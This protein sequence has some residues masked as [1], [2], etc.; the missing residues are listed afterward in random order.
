MP[1]HIR[2]IYRGLFQGF[3]FLV[4]HVGLL[5]Y[6]TSLTVGKLVLPDPVSAGWSEC[7]ENDLQL[8]ITNYFKV[9][10]LC[11]S[12][13]NLM[14]SLL[15]FIIHVLHLLFQ[16]CYICCENRCISSFCYNTFA[17]FTC[18]SKIAIYVVDQVKNVLAVCDHDMRFIYVRIGWEDSAHDSRVLLDAISNPSV[19]FPVPLVG[20]HYVVDAEYRHMP[21]FMAPFKSGS[22]RRSQ[23]AQ[24]RLFNR[25]HSSIRNVTERTFGV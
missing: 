7:G 17:C 2:S 8:C 21:G 3:L 20:K 15:V 13:S 24:K 22:G 1:P 9:Y 19:V 25:R 10:I 14:C 12:F 4:L 18:Y 23:T 6:L 5:N 16:N 11:Y